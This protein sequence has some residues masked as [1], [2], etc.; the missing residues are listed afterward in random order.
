MLEFSSESTEIS[1]CFRI[2]N[3]TDKKLLGVI[4]D[5]KSPYFMMISFLIHTI[6]VQYSLL[7]SPLL[8]G[9]LMFLEGSKREHLEEIGWKQCIDPV[10][11]FG[12]KSHV[13]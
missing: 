8:N 3:Y 1:V 9:F 11:W 5:I 10:I 4:K 13:V 6:S 7:P 2:S 12:L